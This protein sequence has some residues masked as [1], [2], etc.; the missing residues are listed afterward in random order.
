M[1]TYYH[2]DY[3]NCHESK[4]IMIFASFAK[5]KNKSWWLAE[6]MIQEHFAHHLLARG[7]IQM[8]AV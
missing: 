2:F 5:W 6:K 8:L 3:R 4:T 1:F 7:V